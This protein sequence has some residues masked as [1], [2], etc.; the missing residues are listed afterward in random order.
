MS[1][2]SEG[3]GARRRSRGLQAGGRYRRSSFKGTQSPGARSNVQNVHP[4]VGRFVIAEAANE[5][6]L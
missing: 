3:V 5:G 1:G 6:E 4:L 2:G